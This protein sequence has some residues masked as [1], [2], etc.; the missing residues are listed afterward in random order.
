MCCTV[1][2]KCLLERHRSHQHSQWEAFRNMGLSVHWGWQ[3]VIL[4]R[5]DAFHHCSV[6]EH[7]RSSAVEQRARLSLQCWTKPA[8]AATKQLYGPLCLRQ[9]SSLIRRGD[10]PAHTLA[11]ER[12]ADVT[13]SDGVSL[14]PRGKARPAGPAPPVPPAARGWANPGLQKWNM[15]ESMAWDQ[16]KI[17][18][19]RSLV[20]S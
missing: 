13:K 8:H 15:A 18:T 5:K 1:E 4:I 10:D 19:F 12:M 6:S 20:F 17:M 3:G 9:K 14:K 7:A 2:M 16:W 11:C